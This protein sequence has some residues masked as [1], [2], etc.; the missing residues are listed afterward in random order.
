MMS[1]FC[2]GGTFYRYRGLNLETG[3]TTQTAFLDEEIGDRG[4]KVKLTPAVCLLCWEHF[5]G[6]DCGITVYVHPESHVG[7]TLLTPTLG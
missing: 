5:C 6:R 7:R 3:A 1:S 4:G 2:E